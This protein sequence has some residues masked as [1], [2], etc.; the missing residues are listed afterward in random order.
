MCDMTLRLMF[1]II[2]NDCR[3]CL[4]FFF[5]S[6]SCDVVLDNVVSQVLALNSHLQ[7]SC[8]GCRNGFFTA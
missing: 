8:F 5:H 3:V 6:S 7:T 2:I 4:K 1:F